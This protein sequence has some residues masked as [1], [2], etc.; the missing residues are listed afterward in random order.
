MDRRSTRARWL[1]VIG[2]VVVLGAVAV[3]LVGDSPFGP[4]D[5]TTT[6]DERADEVPA[7]VVVDGARDVES[8]VA[9]Q[10]DAVSAAV[11]YVADRSGDEV[12]AAIEQALGPEW[13]RRTTTSDDTTQQVLFDGPDEATLT[14]STRATVGGT[15]VAAVLARG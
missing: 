4:A 6:M 14:I 8:T 10:G 5:G 15:G 2:V 3:A 7:G 1:V 13:Q 11:T 12:L 9:R